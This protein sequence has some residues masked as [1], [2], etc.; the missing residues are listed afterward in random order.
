MDYS[1]FKLGVDSQL[2]QLMSWEENRIVATLI[3][4]QC[5]RHLDIISRLLD[6]FIFNSPEFVDAVRQLVLSRRRPNIRIIV[7]EPETIVRNGHQLVRLAGDLSS[8]IEIRKASN[9]Y[10]YYNECLL[11]AD[12]TAYLHRYDSVR[13]EATANFNDRKKCKYFD[14]Q[15]VEMWESASLDPNLRRM[16]L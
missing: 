1:D 11:L 4:R 8:F 3:A 7:F 12:K 5:K 9:V 6:P 14:E 16:N 15:F 10:K 13:Y 2:L